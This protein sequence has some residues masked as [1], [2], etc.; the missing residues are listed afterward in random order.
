LADPRGLSYELLAEDYDLGR[1]GWPPELVDGIDAQ[2]VLDLGAGTGKLTALLVEHFD[3]VIAV[4][5]LAGMRA[6]LERNVPAAQVLPGDAERI[7]L[8]DGSVD[9]AFAAEAFHWFDSVAAVRELA[10]VLRPGS[11]LVVCFNHWRGGF[12]PAIDEAVGALVDAVY[13]RLPAP[14]GPKVASGEW[15]RGFGRGPFAPLEESAIDHDWTTDREGV[16]AYYVSTSSMGALPSEERLA[17]RAELVERLD[18]VE[19][20]LPLTARVFRTERR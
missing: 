17:L 15:Q 9:A 2:T 20:R 4:E 11:T 19:Y 10:R 12:E 1:S 14:G 7:P 3:E 18:E 5:P 6:V 8:D 13:D 16:A